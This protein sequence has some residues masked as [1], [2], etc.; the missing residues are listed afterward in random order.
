MQT[1][2]GKAA[3]RELRALLVPFISKRV[4]PQDVDDVVQTVF[5][6]IQRGLAD[7]RDTDKLIAWAYQ[8]ARNA[9]VDHARTTSARRYEPLDKVRAATLPVSEDSD[10]P[11][12][13]AALAAI[14]GHFIEMLAE[15][16]REALRQTELE[17]LTQAEA[18]RRAGLSLPGMKSRVQRARAQL[19]ELLE[20]CCDIELDARGAIVDVEPRNRPPSLPDCCDSR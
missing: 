2:I 8:I 10:E 18:A 1:D 4:A 6:R 17:G 16:Y 5:V 15:P 11:A 19:R 20:G 7:L 14:V 13:R 9:I 12:S 3:S